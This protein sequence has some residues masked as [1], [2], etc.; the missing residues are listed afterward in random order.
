MCEQILR[1]N[2][3]SNKCCQGPHS[4]WISVFASAHVPNKTIFSLTSLA[5]EPST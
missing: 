3:V 4:N 1:Q 2:L 5:N